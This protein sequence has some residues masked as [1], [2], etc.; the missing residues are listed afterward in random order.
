[1]TCISIWSPVSTLMALNIS[2]GTTCK[3]CTYSCSGAHLDSCGV[4]SKNC[5]L[6]R[7]SACIVL[8]DCCTW[9]RTLQMVAFIVLADSFPH[10]MSIPKVAPELP[11]CPMPS[12]VLRFMFTGDKPSLLQAVLPANHA[13]HATLQRGCGLESRLPRS[14]AAGQHRTAS[15]RG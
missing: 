6:Q 9:P 13:R 14:A 4:I 10:H 12:E 2:Y 11:G 3:F 8:H 5:V 7:H 15:H 1:M